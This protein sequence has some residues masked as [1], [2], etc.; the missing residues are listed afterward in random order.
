MT[1]LRRAGMRLRIFFLVL[2]FVSVAQPQ[3]TVC[4]ATYGPD[5][6]RYLTLL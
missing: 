6:T 2:A 5:S 1:G 4:L 3:A